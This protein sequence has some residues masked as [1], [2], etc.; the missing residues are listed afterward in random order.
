MI[1]KL[2]AEDDGADAK[3]GGNVYIR[4][5]MFKS[6]TRQTKQKTKKWENEDKKGDPEKHD[7]PNHVERE[8]RKVIKGC[9]RLTRAAG[10][11]G[12]G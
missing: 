11:C 9:Q 12:C 2:V 6:K 3:G 7:S 10:A 4:T 1:K 5:N 8:R